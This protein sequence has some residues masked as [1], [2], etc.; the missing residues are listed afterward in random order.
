MVR[1]ARFIQ[2]RIHF[3]GFVREREFQNNEITQKAYYLPNPHMLTNEEAKKIY[4]KFPL[5][6][7]DV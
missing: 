7:R 6:R 5:K 4:E 3:L 1:A 2:E